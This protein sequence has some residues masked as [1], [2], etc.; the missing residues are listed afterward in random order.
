MSRLKSN[1]GAT[2]TKFHRLYFPVSQSASPYNVVELRNATSLVVK[3]MV[4]IELS[5]LYYKSSG[6]LEK[7]S[8]RIPWRDNIAFSTYLQD[9]FPTTSHPVLSY[10]NS[11]L[12]LDIKSELRATKLKKYLGVS[13]RPTHDIRSHLFFDREAY[14]IEIFHHTTFLKEQ[15]KATKSGGDFSTPPSSIKV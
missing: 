5:A 1:P 4:I 10:V 3:V 13:F 7:G 12:F 9:L 14:I 11:K 15:L 6:R 8:F 2:H